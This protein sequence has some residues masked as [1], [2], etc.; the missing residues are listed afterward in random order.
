[1]PHVPPTLH[2]RDMEEADEE[3]SAT[4]ARKAMASGMR[5][6]RPRG[7]SSAKIGTPLASDAKDGAPL[8]ATDELES[9]RVGWDSE[10]S[11]VVHTAMDDHDEYIKQAELDE[12]ES[13]KMVASHALRSI[14]LVLRDG[15]TVLT[16]SLSDSV[17]FN[18]WVAEIRRRCG[19]Q[20]SAPVRLLWLTRSGCTIELNQRTFAHYVLAHWCEP[21][22]LFVHDDAEAEPQPIRLTHTGRVLFR[23]YDVNQ[24]GR[25]EKRELLRLFKDLSLEQL[26]CSDAFIEQFIDGEFAALDTDGSDGLTRDEVRRRRF[27]R[28]RRRV[29]GDLLHTLQ[30]DRTVVSSVHA[31]T[32]DH[33]AAQDFTSLTTATLALCSSQSTSLR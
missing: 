22:T 29:S 32:L 18:E 15:S 4:D 28:T 14:K 25:V 5:S 31:A 26:G 11:R 12:L 9:H 6:Q 7:A 30:Q 27:K 19:M 1:M 3:A 20:P 17:R 10:F 21:W 8:A 33:L 23:R 13:R 24:N 2:R 16:G